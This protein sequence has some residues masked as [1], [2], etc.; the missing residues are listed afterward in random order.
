MI[1]PSVLGLALF[2]FAP[3]LWA[4]V[5][6]VQSF[7]P[8]T[9]ASQGFVGW[10][11][12]AEVFAD[13]Q[14]WQAAGNTMLYGAIIT[15]VEVPLS[16]AIAILLQRVVPATRFARSAVIAA[17]ACSESVVALLWFEMLNQNT[18]LVNALL[19]AVGIPAVPWL[20]GGYVSLASIIIVS[21]WKDIGLPVL[22]YLAALQSLDPD[23]YDASSLD[24]ATSFQQFRAL[25]IPLL[26]RSTL[27]AVFMVTIGALRVFTPIQLMTQ[28]GPNGDSSNL[29]YY[30]YNQGFLNLDYGVGSAATVCLVL[31]LVVVTAVQGMFLRERS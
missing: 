1:A 9:H 3:L 30:V 14:F 19:G 24:G 23:L 26:Q 2:Q 6:S 16:L 18:G 21:I 28:G 5:E 20:T 12:F 25:T 11:N 8:I 4:M 22:I 7:N 13:G 27:V 29:I 17:L 31:L 15:V 10:D